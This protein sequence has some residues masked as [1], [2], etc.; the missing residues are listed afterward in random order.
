MRRHR[1]GIYGDL[2]MAKELHSERYR[3]FGIVM[4][5]LSLI[6]ILVCIAYEIILSIVLL[7]LALFVWPH[8]YAFGKGMKKLESVISE[9]GIEL[10]SIDFLRFTCR[11]RRDMKEYK[12]SFY[13]S[14]KAYA[15]PDTDPSLAFIWFSIPDHYQI[16]RKISLEPSSVSEDLRSVLENI[17][18][19]FLFFKRKSKMKLAGHI[20]ENNPDLLERAKTIKNLHYISY[21][22]S[23][24]I[25]RGSGEVWIIALLDEQ[26]E[27]K[28]FLQAMDLI[29]TIVERYEKK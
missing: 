14:T 11:V 26:A 16:R 8:F 18:K 28:E 24:P 10:D 20:Y 4:I 22:R 29:D 27:P 9:G 17:R 6:G 15:V 21:M 5:S 19:R 7:F 23:L 12:L 1:V 13:R 3:V 2:K 25:I